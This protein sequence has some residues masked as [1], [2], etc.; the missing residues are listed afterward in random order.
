MIRLLLIFLKNKRDFYYSR[1]IQI[2]LKSFYFKIKQSIIDKITFTDTIS[3]G[4]Q[5]LMI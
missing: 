2:E 5:F 4:K 3:S 1:N